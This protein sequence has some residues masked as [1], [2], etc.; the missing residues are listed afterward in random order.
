[1]PKQTNTDNKGSDDIEKIIQHTPD[2]DEKH[3]LYTLKEGGQRYYAYC[4][5]TEAQV[6]KV[7]AQLLSP[8]NWGYYKTSPYG[9][10]RAYT[11]ITCFPPFT[12]PLRVAE[13]I[14][15]DGRI[16]KSSTR[17]ITSL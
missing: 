5:Q 4:P 9:G 3:W 10:S 6:K 7:E 14:F 13:V 12:P 15:P 8:R 11:Q 17:K 2:K 16:Y 1:M